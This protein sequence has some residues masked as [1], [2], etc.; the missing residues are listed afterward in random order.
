[1]NFS[2]FEFNYLYNKATRIY[3]I[4]LKENGPKLFALKNDVEEVK[5]DETDKDKK[6]E[7]KADLKIEIDLDGIS[8]RISVFPMSS[9]NY[10]DLTA[11][12]GALVRPMELSM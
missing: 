2:S 1:M 10:R 4:S 11:V 5:A 9:G 6:E 12:D 7:S 3:A 8:D